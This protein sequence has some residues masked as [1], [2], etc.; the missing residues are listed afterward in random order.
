[1]L[2]VPHDAELA[3]VCLKCGAHEGITRRPT[4]F[5]WTPPWARLLMIS[6]LGVLLVLVLRKE[7]DLRVPLCGPCN[8]RWSSARHATIAAVILVVAAVAGMRW[9]HGPPLV[10]GLTSIGMIL[11]AAL[12][13]TVFARP[14]TLRATWIDGAHRIH[15]QGF[16]PE[17]AREM[18]DAR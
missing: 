12:A 17:A 10:V 6:G 1:M 3:D 14:R 13:V 9:M 4:T 11:V 7:A 5:Y 18:V 16:A 8:A 15:L 2:V